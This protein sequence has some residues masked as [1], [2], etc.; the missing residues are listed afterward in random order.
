VIPAF[1]N[2]SS[3]KFSRYVYSLF[4]T[5]NCVQMCIGLRVRVYFKFNAPLSQCLQRQGVKTDGDCDLTRCPTGLSFVTIRFWGS[6]PYCD[7]L[8]N[9]K[10][11]P[12]R[13][14]NCKR[15]RRK[16]F[17]CV[18]CSFVKYVVNPLPI[19][20]LQ[21]ESRPVVKRPPALILIHYRHLR[22]PSAAEDEGFSL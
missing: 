20:S 4:P 22:L 8:T 21:N 1:R 3:Y 17:N 2:L 16:I 14:Q 18:F 19:F 5:R 10:G 12:E 15:H 13:P 7:V 6:S 9:K 11:S